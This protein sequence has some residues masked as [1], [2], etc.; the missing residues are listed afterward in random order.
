MKVLLFKDRIK[1]L[2]F[3]VGVFISYF[4]FGIYQQKI[5]DERSYDEKFEFASSFVVLQCFFNFVVAKIVIIICDHPQNETLHKYYM[6]IAVFNFLAQLTSNLALKYVEYVIQV[7]GKSCKPIIIM[8]F[9]VIFA[10]KILY[11]SKE[12]QNLKPLIGNIL[13]ALSLLSEGFL[14]ATQDKMRNV[15]RPTLLNFMFFT[16]LYSTI[17]GSPLLF[18]NFEGLEFIKFC[19]KHNSVIIHILIVIACG[20]C[21]QF[22]ISAMVSNFGSLPLSIVTTIRK[23]CTAVFSALFIKE[24]LNVRQWIATILIFTALILDVLFGKKK[25]CHKVNVE[26]SKDE[27]EQNVEITKF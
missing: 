15:S 10:K 13:I 18:V 23:F 2:A 20:A 19:M 8:I 4:V 7:V 12:N 21:G 1:L 24:V 14:G 27:K 9:G 22:F 3:A 11:D 16:N 25:F 5:Y 6:L 26:E 17:F